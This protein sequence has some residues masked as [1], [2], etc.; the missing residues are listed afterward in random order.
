MTTADFY[1]QTALQYGQCEIE[2]G[3][4]LYSPAGIK[5]LNLKEKSGRPFDHAAADYWLITER[6][7]IPMYGAENITNFLSAVKEINGGYELP[8]TYKAVK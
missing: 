5:A 6:K 2:K 8:I 1:A 3:I 4:M 7:I